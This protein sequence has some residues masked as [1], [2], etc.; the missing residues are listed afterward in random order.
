MENV[1]KSALSKIVNVLTQE[2]IDYMIVGGFAVSYHNRVRTTNDIDLVVQ[3]YPSGVDLIVKHFPEWIGMVDGFKESVKLGQ[4]FN[5]TDFETGIRYDFISYRDSDYNW[6][7]F[8]R[9]HRVNFFD[10][11]C[12]LC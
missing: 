6:S 11:D 10:I 1:F 12:Y 9:R 2:E 8:Q 4:L 3:I 7:A 5:I